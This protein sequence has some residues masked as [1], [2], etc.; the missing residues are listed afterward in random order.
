MTRLLVSC[1]LLL[2]V[3]VLSIGCGGSGENLTEKKGL[4]VELNEAS[5]QPN[6]R[7][8]NHSGG[9]WTHLHKLNQ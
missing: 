7:R 8:A 9:D 3:L 5:C 6:W 2:A 1:L 4:G